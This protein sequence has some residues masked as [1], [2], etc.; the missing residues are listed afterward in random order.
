[1]IALPPLDPSDYAHA[2]AWVKMPLS[3]HTLFCFSSPGTDSTQS[4]CFSV[5]SRLSIVLCASSGQF[6]A[7]KSPHSL[8]RSSPSSSG[9]SR[10]QKRAKYHRWVAKQA[11]RYFPDITEC[12]SFGCFKHTIP[13]NKP[14][15]PVFRGT[16]VCSSPKQW[17]RI[18][19]Q[20]G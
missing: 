20:E 10:F 4:S 1:M 9:V 19:R 2:D 3:I 15:F 16:L 14:I 7:H 13:V 8:T 12:H 6:Y 18:C 17:R 5:C 11:L